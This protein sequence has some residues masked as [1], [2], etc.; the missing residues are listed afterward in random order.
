V[1]GRAI[2]TFDEFFDLK[3][4]RENQNAS[5]SRCAVTEEERR[6]CRLLAWIVFFCLAS[7]ASIIAGLFRG[8][9]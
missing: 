7:A 3:Y 9:L 4:C 5:S 8:Q 1:L 6:V 2:L